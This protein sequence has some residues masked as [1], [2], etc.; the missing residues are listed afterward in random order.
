MI[1]AFLSLVKFKGNTA[2]TSYLSDVSISFPINTIYNA[3]YV[4]ILES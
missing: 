4:V 1:V 2:S 3:K